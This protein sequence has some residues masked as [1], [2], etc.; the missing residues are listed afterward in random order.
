MS[1]S[2]KSHSFICGQENWSAAVWMI[3]GHRSS[4]AFS[5][6]SISVS[7]T[8]RRTCCVWVEF[9]LLFIASRAVATCEE[10]PSLLDTDVMVL[11]FGALITFWQRSVSVA[12]GDKYWR[13][14]RTLGAFSSY[15]RQLGPNQLVLICTDEV[16]VCFLITDRP[17]T[18]VLSFHASLS[19]CVQLFHPFSQFT[20]SHINIYSLLS[21]HVHS[22]TCQS[23]NVDVLLINV[24]IL[25][26]IQ[27]FRQGRQWRTE[28]D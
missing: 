17:Q 28:N 9:Q 5:D 3:Q 4:V 12:V 21:L 23:N 19:S 13:Q 6:S 8:S 24:L 25:L 10:L 20:W 26:S 27:R 15:I 16:Q 22:L 18:G 2:F 1:V 14:R 11:M 7:E